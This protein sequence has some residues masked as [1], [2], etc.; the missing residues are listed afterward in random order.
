M[1]EN[2]TTRIF[3]GIVAAVLMLPVAGTLV[4]SIA[5]EKPAAESGQF[6][7]LKYRLIGPAA[8]G[9]VSRSAGVAGDPRV[10]Y[11]GT[12]S[13]GVWKSSD[14]GYR[15]KPVLDEQPV[16]SIGSL[17]VAPSDSNVIYVG[18]GEANIRGDVAPG[19]G[20]Y[21]SIDAGKTWTRVW[22][23]EGQI[24]TIAVHP[25]NP[26]IAFAAVLGHAFGPNP[27]RGVYRTADGG[28]TWDRVLSKDVDTGASDICF[29]T[30][31]PSVLFA[32]MWQ[33]RRFPW[34][35]TS[36]G[37]GSGL[38]V[39]RDGGST[40]KQL[41]REN[42][43]PEGTLGKIGVAVAPS[44]SRRVYAL[45]EAEKGGLYR[46]DDGGDSWTLVHS[47]HGIRQRAF[48]YTTLTVDP[49]NP[50]VIWFPQVPMLRSIDG[51]YTVKK[52]KGF[53][54]GD[55]HD[56]WIDPADS[57]R[58]IDSNDGGVEI[59][60][61]GG[62]TWYA[63]PLPIS[64]FYHVAADTRKPYYVSGAMQDLGTACGPSNSLG[65]GGIGLCDWYS[66]GGGEAGYTA[67]DPSDP[68]IVYAGEYGGYI[69]R[70][71][72]RTRQVT[73]VGVYPDVISGHGAADQRYR[74][75]W[76]APILIS[77][78]DPKT[79][80]HGGNVLFK[81]TDGGMSWT[82]ISPDLTRNDK[83]KQQWSGGP[84]T[85]D[86]SGAE[87]YC[88]IFALA[89][90]PLQKG[91]IWAG[92]DDGLVHITRD[93]AS[94][95]TDVT[96][97]IAGLPEWG[98]VSIIEASPF[99]AATAY[100]VVDAHRLDNMKPYV[101]KTTDFGAT[102]KSL[103]AGLPQDVYLHSLRE[104]PRRRGMLYAGSE[105]G[106]FYSIDDGSTW[107][108]L[109]LNLPDVAVHDLLVKGDDLVLATHGRSAWILDD[110]TPIRAMSKQIEAEDAHFFDPPA[111]V[112][113][114][115]YY[116]SRSAGSFDNP[117]PGAILNYFLKGK[118]KEEVKM[119]VLD[120]SGAV[121][122][123]LSSKPEEKQSSEFEYEDE[124]ESK[125]VLGTEP[126]VNRAFW[127]LMYAG[128][129][130]IKNARLDEGSLKQGPM[131]LPGAYTLRLNADGKAQTVRLTVEPDPR[132][133]VSQA[134]LESQFKLSLAISD[135]I[136]S[137]AEVVNRI[138]SI[139]QQL[140]S[141]SDLLKDNPQAARLID[142]SK[143]LAGKLDDLEA[144]LHNPKAEI[145][146][147]IMAQPG[148]AMLYSKLASL[149]S[150]VQSSD[151]RPTQGMTEIYGEYR[152]QLDALTKDF[153]ALVAGP[154]ADINRS[155]RD[156]KLPHILV[157]EMPAKH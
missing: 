157:Q 68:N 103:A 88:T 111:A 45:I 28:K 147:D 53:Q 41:T 107:R 83:S 128:P 74:F 153:Q 136:S 1:G 135:A 91:V 129:A 67:H 123:T 49:N 112:R 44:D 134:D 31:N 142:S 23:Q 55:H 127:D 14:G 20:I 70:Y 141:L 150:T 99:D 84:I 12:A 60:L 93:G 5:Q 119:E 77:P 24:G 116:S 138:R 40:W 3:R 73:N 25:S 72:H 155:A 64:Q 51:G 105:H 81:T 100:V 115:Q 137:L 13:G 154:V 110:L 108:P 124:E 122:R 43:L 98:T 61:D 22:K 109:K 7:N 85:G 97:K 2:M 114:R 90:S 130:R 50:D 89:E 65:A 48:Y 117:P 86:N 16:S 148:G 69:S 87:Y 131:A 30:K 101:W 133:A 35:M 56:I 102:W 4:L 37:P 80:Y 39:S 156:L 95:W 71:D 104:D 121:I 29:D 82:A 149:H 144:K 57:R 47:G 92:T 75:Q 15:W 63:P 36:G 118:A 132:V 58:L 27:E 52:V 152:R 78:H 34:G 54:H 76:T 46:S 143:E 18:T 59:S 10:Y 96:A 79:I 139:R 26:D 38:Y 151:S 32:G 126:G 113:Y 9:R 21:R 62:E 17:A 42:G 19:N 66:V 106:V 6:K 125:D 146:Y 33:A 94:T 8:G 11:A 140:N 145:S 120:A